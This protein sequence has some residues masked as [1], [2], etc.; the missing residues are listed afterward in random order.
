VHTQHDTC[1]VSAPIGRGNWTFVGSISTAL[2]G[3]DIS[4]RPRGRWQRSPR[5]QCQRPSRCRDQRPS[6]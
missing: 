5:D 3:V 2:R 4:G 1:L 6:A